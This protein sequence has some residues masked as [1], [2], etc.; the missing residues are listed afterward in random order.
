MSPCSSSGGQ[1]HD[2]VGPLGGVGQFHDLEAS[3]PSAF[4]AEAEPL[5]RAMATSLTPGVTQIERMGMALAAIADDG[6]LLALDQVQVGIPVVI[7]THYQP[8]WRLGP[9]RIVI[10]DAEGFRRRSG[11]GF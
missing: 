8:L 1:H 4:L 2:H 9:G 6:D 11:R 5:R 10:K 7:N 3:S